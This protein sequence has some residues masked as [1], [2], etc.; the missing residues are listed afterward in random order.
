MLRQ[1]VLAEAPGKGHE[2]VVRDRAG[3]NDVHKE[4][5]DSRAKSTNQQLSKSANQQINQINKSTKS[6]NQQINE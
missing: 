1:Q 3:D 6:T 2:V 4:A 5:A